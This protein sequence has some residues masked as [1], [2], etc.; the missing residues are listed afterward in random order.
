LNAPARRPM[1][2]AAATFS[3]VN[4]SCFSFS[5][6]HGPA[7]TPTFFPPSG[8]PFWP[9]LI[10]VVSFLTSR[11]A[12]LYGASIGTIRSTFGAVSIA[13]LSTFRLSPRQA[14]TVRLVPTIICSLR[15]YS[16]T[17]LTTWRT[18]FSDAPSFIITII[19]ELL[20]LRKKQ[21]VNSQ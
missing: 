5:T 14:I 8:K 15:P 2:P 20:M 6:E 12:I 4:N 10:C 18:S 1:Q 17:S 13:P 16:L 9:I 11:D 7:I 19:A 3:A 21:R